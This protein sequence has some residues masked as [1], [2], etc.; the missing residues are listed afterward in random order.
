[1]NLSKI[2]GSQNNSALNFVSGLKASEDL[3]TSEN[4]RL[5]REIIQIEKDLS[6]RISYLERQK[7]MAAFKLGECDV[8]QVC[9]LCMRRRL[10]GDL[11][12]L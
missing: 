2:P 9:W 1:M 11:F 5:K 3:L 10:L 8:L 12:T 6:E 7:A 4:Q